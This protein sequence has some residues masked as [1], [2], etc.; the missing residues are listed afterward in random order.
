[1]LVNVV[2]INRFCFIE[3]KIIVNVS[4]LC[5]FGLVFFIWMGDFVVYI[6][7]VCV[8]FYSN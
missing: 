8:E 7:V 1:M 6:N 3:F 5:F 2:K 4:C